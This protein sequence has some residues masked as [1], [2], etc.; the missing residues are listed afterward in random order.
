MKDYIA[1]RAVELAHYII[2]NNSTVRKAAAAFNV[3]KS[4]VHKDVHERLRAI[5]PA[6]Y[7]QAQKV[8]E[9]NKAERHLRGGMATRAKYLN[10]SQFTIHNSQLR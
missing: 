5:N 9:V 2:D 3:S 10:N 8:L 6:L 4:T 7:R 1:Q